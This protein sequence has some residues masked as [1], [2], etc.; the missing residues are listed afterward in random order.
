MQNREKLGQKGLY[1][2]QKSFYE[3]GKNIFGKGGGINI[4]FGPKYRSLT[5]IAECENKLNP[6]NTA[7][8][9]YT[10]QKAREI[11]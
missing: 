10:K 1:K 3:R 4:F 8:K 6:G 7:E 9:K 5:H 11:S 2:R